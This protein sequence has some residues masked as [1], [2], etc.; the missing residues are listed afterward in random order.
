MRKLYEW[1]YDEDEISY[2]DFEKKATIVIAL[3]IISIV[4]TILIKL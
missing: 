3:L 1:L 2:E 4:T